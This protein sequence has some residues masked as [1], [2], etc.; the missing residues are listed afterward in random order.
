MAATD[1]I[2]VVVHGYLQGLEPEHKET[3]DMPEVIKKCL[4]HGILTDVKIRAREKWSKR[5]G[6]PFKRQD[7]RVYKI[8]LTMGPVS[9]EWPLNPRVFLTNSD[10]IRNLEDV[11]KLLMAAFWQEFA[12]HK[13]LTH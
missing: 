5:Y 8:V 9:L 13:D 10:T 4:A 1:K 11:G 7:G 6:R 2:P 12:G 3:F